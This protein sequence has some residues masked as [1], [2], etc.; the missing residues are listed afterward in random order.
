MVAGYRCWVANDS[1]V[2]SLA[3]HARSFAEK[4]DYTQ[5]MDRNWRVFKAKW[6][7]PETNEVIR[8]TDVNLLT[9]REFDAVTPY[10]DLSGTR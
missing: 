2:H 8:G 6:S 5:L 4:V 3:D 10:I 9:D 7:I 1:F